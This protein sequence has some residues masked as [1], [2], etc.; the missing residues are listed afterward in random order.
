MYDA[1]QADVIILIVVFVITLLL[2]FRIR[3]I[4]KW[5]GL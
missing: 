2:H 3:E 5:M 4:E 1:F